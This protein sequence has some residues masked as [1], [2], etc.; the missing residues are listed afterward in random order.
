MLIV[1]SEE[2]L[3]DYWIPADT[4]WF[5]RRAEIQQII[6][7]SGV[8]RIGEKSFC[9]CENLTSIIFSNDVTSIG[10]A[11]FQE[12]YSLTTIILPTGLT[13]IG[14]GAFYNCHNLISITIPDSVTSIEERAFA[15]C[16]KLTIYAPSGSYA[17][18]YAKD[19]GIPFIAQ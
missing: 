17:E 19:H 8:T 15:Y 18:Q 16:E 2:M 6:I 11:A 14:Y 12:C 5:E 3:L 4:P 9:A 1:N 13:E 7:E 10:E